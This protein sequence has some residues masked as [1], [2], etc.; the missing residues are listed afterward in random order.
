MTAS[1][2]S[3][4]DLLGSANTDPGI[5]SAAYRQFHTYSIGNQLLAWGQCMARDIQPGP[6]ATFMGCATSRKALDSSVVVMTHPGEGASRVLPCTNLYVPQQFAAIRC[7]V[8][9]STH[10]KEP[11]LVGRVMTTNLLP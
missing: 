7:S 6:I 4:A 11:R 1:A 8:H 5:I 9:R 10:K 3:F 2:A